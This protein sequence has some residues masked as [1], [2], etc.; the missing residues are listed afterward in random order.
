MDT[1]INHSAPCV[2]S[3]H[4][5]VHL[6]LYPHCLTQT[7]CFI[8][9]HSLIFLTTRGTADVFSILY[10]QGCLVARNTST[11]CTE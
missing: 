4:R 1:T 3:Y 8:Q 6:S 5:G 2:E 11:V 10:Q 9:P 7:L